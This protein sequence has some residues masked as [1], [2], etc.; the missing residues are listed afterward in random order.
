MHLMH[1]AEELI[2]E[3]DPTSFLDRHGVIEYDNGIST[4]KE[5][6]L[7]S[8]KLASQVERHNL[9]YGFSAASLSSSMG[10]GN[11]DR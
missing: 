11:A 10:G 6:W 9:S 2:K 7:A 1:R 3:I 4:A 5:C 8:T